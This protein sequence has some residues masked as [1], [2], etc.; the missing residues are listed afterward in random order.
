MT[1]DRR[2]RRAAESL[3]AEVADEDVE[4][5]LAALHRTGSRPPRRWQAPVAAAVLV[6]ALAVGV[7]VV[8]P[9]DDH[10]AHPVAPVLPTLGTG[11][12]VLASDLSPSGRRQ[13]VATLRDGQPAVVLVRRL[14]VGRSQVVWSG[15]TPQELV[16]ANPS[17]AVAV[18]WSPSG[19]Q[20]ALLVAR[21][22]YGAGAAADDDL[23][24]LTVAPD[25]SGR[26]QVPA[27]LGVCA[28]ADALPALT[29]SAD[30][31]ELTVAVPGRMTTRHVHVTVP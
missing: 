16:R 12:H 9:G 5:R 2:G 7:T 24:L 28:C 1:V 10:A 27:D 8:R 29:W 22:P 14:G 3:W 4:A 25:G 20:I 13:A 26:R 17:H 6:G 19:R 15:E 11:Y 23:A 18:A 21:R 30:G 31:R